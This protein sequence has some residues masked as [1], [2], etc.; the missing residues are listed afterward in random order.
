MELLRYTWRLFA[1]TQKRLW[2]WFVV[3]AVSSAFIVVPHVMV[4]RMVDV[5]IPSMEVK[6]VALYA[7]LIAGSFVLSSLLQ[8]TSKYLLDMMIH[9]VISSIK[10]R[11]FTLFHQKRLRDLMAIGTDSL[12]QRATNTVQ[13]I[14]EKIL[15]IMRDVC[16]VTLSAVI[17]FV[18]IANIDPMIP[19]LFALVFI[20]YIYFRVLIFRKKG[21]TFNEQ[22]ESNGQIIRTVRELIQGIRSIKLNGTELQEKERFELV[23]KKHIGIQLHH[24]HVFSSLL[25]LNILMILLPEIIVYGYLGYKVYTG[26]TTIGNILVAA[27]LLGQIRAFVWQVSRYGMMMQEFKVHV[28]RLYEI[29]QLPDE[30]YGKG[31]EWTHVDSIRGGISFENV[32][33]QYDQMK[34][35]DRF[36]FDI[37]PG[38]SIGIVGISGVGKTTL[39]NLFIGLEAPSEGV[40]R[41]DGRPLADW[42]ISHVR[43]RI[44]FI[45]QQPYLLNG[46]IRANT[47]YGLDGKSDTEIYQALDS[48]Y[49]KEFV[50][51][52]ENG[53]DTLIGE[54]G[55]Q[56]SGGQ[57]QRLSIARAFLQNPEIIVLDEATA[58]LDLESEHLVQLALEPLCKNKTTLIIAHRLATLHHTDQIIVIE[59][60]RIAESGSHMELL[61]EKG[62]YFQLYREQYRFNLEE[63]VE[64]SA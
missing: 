54:R 39:A 53:L 19:L 46:T 7:V 60:G 51:S 56:L 40:I 16:A 27:G 43:S 52:L 58:S 45:T 14:Q 41:L 37:N 63:S 34:V 61:Q 55:I 6:L 30:P 4:G 10:V 21:Y 5:A 35:L 13:V 15:L 44:C 33:F 50:E 28:Q 47:T 62:L 64:G 49:L 20:P 38:V 1:G 36:N 3:M 2:T 9:Q 32:T 26:Q 29:E 12:Y 57:K 31:S 18:V 23:Q 8:S 42:S 24:I 22:A 11:L 25:L 17:S 48:A 59:D